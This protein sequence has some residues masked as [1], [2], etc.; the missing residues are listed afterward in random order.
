MTK[1]K[2]I[3]CLY[4]KNTYVGCIGDKRLAEGQKKGLLR[5]WENLVPSDIKI[6]KK[7]NVC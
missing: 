5:T 7:L 4:I 6:S 3:Y 2:Y 1:P